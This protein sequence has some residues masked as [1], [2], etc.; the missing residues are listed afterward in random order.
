MRI[1]LKRGGMSGRLSFSSGLVRAGL[2]R[3]SAIALAFGSCFIIP[4]ATANTEAVP[5]AICSQCIGRVYGLIQRT[6][7]LEKA[8]LRIII[9]ANMTASAVLEFKEATPF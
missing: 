2:V 1:A 7:K 3:R 6:C 8:S 4:S 9:E 5:R